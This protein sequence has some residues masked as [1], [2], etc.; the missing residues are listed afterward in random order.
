[1][2]ITNSAICYQYLIILTGLEIFLISCKKVS[3][4][5]VAKSIC[6]VRLIKLMQTA[7]YLTAP[8][9]NDIFLFSIK[10]TDVVLPQNC[11][12]LSHNHPSK[13]TNK[14]SSSY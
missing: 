2:I 1:M 9:G 3:A 11:C 12:F 4:V 8:F 5:Q 14:K 6:I 10:E 13:D 7:K